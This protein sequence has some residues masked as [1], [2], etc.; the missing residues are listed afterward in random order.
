M[1]DESPGAAQILVMRQQC[2]ERSP[3][4]VERQGGE[5][6]GAPAGHKH[7]AGR[8]EPWCQEWLCAVW[9]RTGSPPGEG[10]PLRQEGPG[11]MPP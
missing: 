6:V 1:E 4:E 11:Q 10:L 7:W 9:P 2:W 8:G 5:L 3:W